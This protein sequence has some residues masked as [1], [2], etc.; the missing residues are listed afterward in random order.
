M[1]LR[2]CLVSYP[3]QLGAKKVILKLKPYTNWA[4]KPSKQPLNIN[5][6][7]TTTSR[8]SI[9]CGINVE[10]C[11][12]YIAETMNFVDEADVGITCFISQLP[13]FRGILKQRYADFIVNEV[14]LDGN[15]V[16]LTSL[17][18]PPEIAE[19]KVVK[20]ADE[21]N[22][23]YDAEIESFR[24]LA[25]DADANC[26]RAFIDQ[27]NSGAEESV[28][29]ITLS[30][31][32]DKSHRTAMHNFFKENMKFLVTDT[33]DGPDTS[34]KC[35]RVRLNS[36]VNAGRGKNSRKRKERN[37]K[38]YD[39]RGSK[40]WPENLGKFIKFHLY[41]E[42]KDTQEALG[43]I[44]K[45]LGIQPRSF[46]FA[47]T[48][49]KRAISTQRVTLYKVRASRLAA[50]NARLIG[51][52]IGDFCHVE[53]GLVLGQ[54]YG[55]KFT[56]T[57]RGVTADSDDTIKASADALGRRGFIN[58]FGLQRFGSGSVPTHIIG[59]AL[60]RG[61]WKAAVQMI[62][63]PR[64]GERENIREVREYYKESDDI[65][66]T[67]R[68]LPRHLVAERA[69]LQ[70]LKKC[71]GNYL[72]A[73]K[74]IPRTLRMMYVHSYQ[75]YL[76]NHAA[77]TRVQKYG[78]D[79]VVLGDLVLCKEDS[80]K[81]TEEVIFDAELEDNICDD[82]DDCSHLDDISNTIAAE[83]KSAV[84]KAITQENL[85]A[86][87]Y[88]VED[89]VL[90]LPGSRVTYPLND[91]GKV[92]HDIAK[93][94]D[95]N[96]KESAHGIKEFSITSMTGAYRRVFQKPQDFKWEMLTYTD[97]NIPL[98]ETDLDVVN[99]ILVKEDMDCGRE[100]VKHQNNQKIATVGNDVMV[101]TNTD[102]PE[103]N[104]KA[105]SHSKES[106]ASS[107]EE[108]KAVKMSFTLPS[109]CYATM[110][111]RELLKSSTSVA[112]HKTLN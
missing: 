1:A 79:Q 45:M 2:G 104:M 57:L 71:P 39:S 74:A 77:S 42:N 7:T 8:R 94:D 5:I 17:V 33:V 61:E 106:L 75:S 28:A 97:G 19:E 24:V 47:G 93:K 87:D 12:D 64:E 68:Q 72:M 50:L 43:V 55:N 20:M 86:G 110:A 3:L 67:L 18:A 59:A 58:Y 107:H 108:Q 23:S 48:K 32:S 88:T 73:L 4:L 15:V 10:I 83:V 109:S 16:H 70:C 101:P 53:D 78:S 31:S 98:A 92:Y 100:D 44:G 76:W 80:G 60:F 89:V 96:L 46:G 38:S 82:P 29:H 13:G 26:L 22:K 63:D 105:K 37:E 112:F 30:P 111:I 54:L 6:I 40:N 25:G 91:I 103:N 36:S 84:V 85:L 21:P 9:C 65:E 56:I 62:L 99:R 11:L 52:K 27:I 81:A 95:V 69:I 90:P 49:D 66:G 51:I 102:E 41:K 34:S 14:D 35:I